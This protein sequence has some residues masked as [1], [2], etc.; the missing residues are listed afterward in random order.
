MLHFK[1]NKIVGMY[2]HL[3]DVQRIQKAQEIFAVFLQ[4]MEFHPSVQMS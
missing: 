3:D 1:V 4:A 2:N